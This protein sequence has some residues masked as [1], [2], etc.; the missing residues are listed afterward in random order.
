MTELVKGPFDDTLSELERDEEAA[1]DDDDERSIN[2]ELLACD[3]AS[4]SRS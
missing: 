1:D 3:V 2:L 4:T